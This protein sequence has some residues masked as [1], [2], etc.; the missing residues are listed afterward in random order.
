MRGKTEKEVD[1][2]LEKISGADGYK[3]HGA[4]I[5]YSEA[6]ELGFRVEY[7]PPENEL[8][9]KIWLLYCL[10]D[11]DSKEKGAGRIIEGEKLSIARPPLAQS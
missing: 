9:K 8:W 7:L 1:A 11:V 5:D 10:Y 6:V 4:V 3:S 2:A